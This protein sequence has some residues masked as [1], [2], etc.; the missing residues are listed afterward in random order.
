MNGPSKKCRIGRSAAVLLSALALS[1]GFVAAQEAAPPA[2]LSLARAVEI[3]L[4]GHPDILLAREEVKAAAARRLQSEARPDPRLSVETGGIPWTLKSGEVETEYGLGLE[5]E[6]EFPGR[7]TARIE[8]ARRDEESASLEIERAG[9]LLVARVK[10]AY[11]RAVFTEQTVAAL[12]ALG[13]ML[14]RFL[15]AML[16]RF[17][18]GEAAYADLLRAKVEKA[19]LQNRRIEGRRDMTIAKAELLLL[20]GL[21]SDSP[22]RLTD[23]LAFQPLKISLERLLDNA[24]AGRPSLRLAR[25]REARAE[26]EMRLAALA[27]KPDFAAGIFIPSK[28]YRGWGFSL[29]LS[30]PLSNARADGLQAEAAAAKGKG[31]IETAA[32][33]RRLAVQ[34]GAA[35]AEAQAAGEQV[36]VFEQKLLGEIEAEI[37]NGLEQYR[38]GRLEAYSLLDLFRSLSEARLEHLN[39]LYLYALAL[40]GLDAAGEEF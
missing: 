29:G 20:L 33:E 30:L 34:I 27:R 37:K 12:E 18:S 7:R 9:L 19:R 31:L 3:A 13:S 10:N 38:L 21:A 1:S 11:H 23:G 35:Y 14:D 26:A 6:F 17:E 16:I 15:E 25:L 32:L 5:R 22:V 28:N 36:R 2:E 39:A 8:I 4:A 40:A 24:R